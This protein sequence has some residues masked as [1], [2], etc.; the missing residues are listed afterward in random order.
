MLFVSLFPRLP[1]HSTISFICRFSSYLPYPYL[2]LYHHTPQYII[3]SHLISLYLTLSRQIPTF[4]I[5]CRLISSYLALSS[6]LSP[7]LAL[8]I[9]I[10]TYI[11]L[12]SFISLYLVKYI[13]ISSH[14][15]PRYLISHY[16]ALSCHNFPD[17]SSSPITFSRSRLAQPFLMSSRVISFLSRFI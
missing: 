6:Q 16:L 10:S 4:L 5:L 9:H 11:I 12:S 3:K 7:Y 2:A 15:I 14:F 1:L 8:S 17:L 13:L